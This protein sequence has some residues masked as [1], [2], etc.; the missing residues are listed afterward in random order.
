MNNNVRIK[1]IYAKY[2]K[3]DGTRILVDCLWPRGVKKEE[4]HIDKWIKD[5]AP[6]GSLRKWYN[7]EPA[8]WEEFKEKYFDEL[9]DKKVM[10][11]D[12]LKT[13]KANIT[14]LYAARDKQYNNANALKEYLDRFIF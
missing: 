13:G 6:S 4:A 3:A 12:L 11:K 5:I 1:R 8:K 7:H 10:L 2:D 9:N 14:L